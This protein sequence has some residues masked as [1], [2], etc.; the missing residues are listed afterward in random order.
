MF[1]IS[2]ILSLLL[3]AG[4]VLSQTVSF[5]YDAAGNRVKREV[6]QTCDFAVNIPAGSNNLSPVMGESVTLTSDCTGSGCAGVTYTWTG[7]NAA[8]AGASR[9]FYAPAASGAFKYVVT[10]TKSGCAVKKDS[11]IL[12]VQPGGSYVLS[13]GCYTMSRY[14]FYLQPEMDAVAAR[15]KIYPP[16]GNSN[17]IFQLTGVDGNAYKILSASANLVWEPSSPVQEWSGTYLREW[18]NTD[19]QKWYIS[20]TKDAGAYS[21]APKANTTRVMELAGGQG[22]S[23]NYTVLWPLN[24]LAHQSYILT[25]VTCPAIGPDCDFAVSIPSG[26][27]NLTPTMGQQTTLTAACSGTGCTGVTYT[28]SGM[29]LTGTGSTSPQFYAPGTTGAF[30][31]TVTA[32]KAGC[33]AKTATVV[34]NVQAGGSYVLSNG[35]YTMS[36]YGSY[37]QP[38]TNGVGARIRIY[39]PTG[40][41]N[42]IFQLIGVDGD[43]YQ[44]TSP[45]AGLV[46]EP[47]SP[48]DNYSGTYLRTWTGIT[49]QKWY[50]SRA[51]LADSYHFT[52]KA[53]PSKVM[54]LGGGMST[55]GNGTVLWPYNALAHQSYILL[56]VGCPGAR[57]A[58]VEVFSTPDP[59]SEVSVYPNPVND[60]LKISAVSKVKSLQI[61]NVLGI[62]VYDTTEISVNGIDMTSFSVGIYLVKI[63]QKDGSFHNF[64]VVKN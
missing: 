19:V 47:S 32:S 39:P 50:V 13:N 38:E 46:W 24:A 58:A 33:T 29:N 2:T 42:Q 45:W 15:M 23:G 4:Q 43:S 53:N 6:S 11:V 17:Q 10:A 20:R 64:K 28:W 30:T 27:N 16:T 40:T 48:I 55:S 26:S 60:W 52:P 5:Q 3:F 35:C 59:D 54:E 21:F 18:I 63:T 49:A 8:G 37:L 9:T 36:R 25:S 51:K 57:M 41:R 34:V 61:Y 1:K 44:V 62:E 14:N 7:I 12:N 22:T 56:P 31:Y